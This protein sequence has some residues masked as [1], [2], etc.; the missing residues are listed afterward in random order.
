MFQL[1]DVIVYLLTGT[2]WVARFS[3]NTRPSCEFFIVCY[4]VKILLSSLHF[5]LNPRWHIKSF[6]FLTS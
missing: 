5:P 1:T 2:S 4:P 3:R 6:F